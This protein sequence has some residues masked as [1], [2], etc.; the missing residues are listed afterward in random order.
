MWYYPNE[1]YN[2]KELLAKCKYVKSDSDYGKA[3]QIQL[4]SGSKVLVRRSDGV[5]VTVATSPYPLML[6]Q[7]V[8]LGQW[9]KATRLCRFIK[10]RGAAAAGGSVRAGRGGRGM[11]R[12]H[13][14]DNTRKAQQVWNA[15]QYSFVPPK[16]NVH[17]LL[18]CAGPQHLGHPRRHGHERQGAQHC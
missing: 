14:S 3:S 1:V 12:Y 15:Y 4:F 17:H 8:K 6:Y 7:L 18:L 2:D 9:D 5:L 11:Y 13:Q 16:A 10:V